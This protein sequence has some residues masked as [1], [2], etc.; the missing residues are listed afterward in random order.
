MSDVRPFRSS[1]ALAWWAEV[2]RY[3]GGRLTPFVSYRR[4]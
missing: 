1:A 4:A 3:G 2:I